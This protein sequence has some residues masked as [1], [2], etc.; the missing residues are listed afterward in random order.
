MKK[1]IS[2]F[3]LNLYTKLLGF[4]IKKGKKIK[5]KK[6]IDSTFL[7]LSKRTNY[8]ISF[9][10]YKLFYKLNVFVEAKL[11]RIKRRTHIV[12]FSVNFKRRSYLIVKWLIKAVGE[13]K[14]NIPVSEKIIEEILAVFK[15]IASNALKFR[16][17]NNSQVLANRSNMHYRW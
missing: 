1:N 8:S 15:G 2:K 7:N 14:K 17:L 16:L 6:I 9:L 4:L 11:V 10:L 5:A 13:N 3:Q 12:P